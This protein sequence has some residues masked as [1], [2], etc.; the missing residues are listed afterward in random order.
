MDHSIEDTLAKI[1]ELL[2]RQEDEKEK[3][4]KEIRSELSKFNL[5][6]KTDE[7]EEPETHLKEKT[8]QN[9]ME[10][11]EN[12]EDANWESEIEEPLLVA[13]AG[14]N[15]RVGTTHC[16]VSIA[17]HL[18]R[19]RKRIAV[20]EFN[21]SG[22]FAAMGKYFDQVSE[23]EFFYKD[24]KY[25]A[26]CTLQLLDQIAASGKYDFL[27][28]DLGNYSAEKTVFSRSDLK[29]IVS[30]GKPW[31]LDSLF[32]IFQE[33]SKN[34]LFQTNFIFNF[35]PEDGKEVIVGGMGELENVY[36]SSFI[37]DPF[38]KIDESIEEIFKEY[39]DFEDVPVKNE[40]KEKKKTS[41][42]LSRRIR[43]EKNEGRRKQKRNFVQAVP[44]AE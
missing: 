14:T 2:T 28:L 15:K 41:K 23:E 12:H 7:S 39:T 37:D 16:A 35:V 25:Y 6:S 17:N 5:S 33:I 21:D 30:G 32:P 27:V 22:E 38:E 40:S 24:V 44:A 34:I 31:E 1:D 19:Q 3:M 42:M 20:M 29:F 36:F 43:N 11:L 26:G 4:L 18:A 13:V 10:M 9:S 8:Q